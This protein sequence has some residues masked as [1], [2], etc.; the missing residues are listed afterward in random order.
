MRYASTATLWALS[1][2]IGTA[3]AQQALFINTPAALVECQPAL[4]NYGGGSGAPYFIAALPAGQVSA[5]PILQLPEQQSTSYTW[6]VS[7]P[8]GTNITLSIRDS[9]GAVQYSSPVA[10]QSGVSSACLDAAGASSASAAG[11][12]SSTASGVASSALASSAPAAATTTLAVSSAASSTLVSSASSATITAAAGSPSS[13]PNSNGTET[14]GSSYNFTCG[15]TDGDLT[16]GITTAVLDNVTL[17]EAVAYFSNWTAAVPGTV[18]ASN[19]T[20]VGAT[21]EWSFNGNITFAETLQTNQTN[22]TTGSLQQQW[23]FTTEADAVALGDGLILNAAFNDLTI[24]TNETSN[25][26]SIQYFILA[27]FNDQA[28]GL[29]A[30]AGLIDASINYYAQQIS[31]GNNATATS[32]PTAARRMVKLF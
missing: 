11:A 31:G 14:A 18:T 8:A 6:T 25:A 13:V 5:A 10:I 15:P 28:E 23:N 12:I 27:C 3:L 21:R 17:A 9:S 4:L 19:G 2:L 30:L 29:T 22:S 32:A 7:L 24:Y 20:G 26:T 1:A 16:Y